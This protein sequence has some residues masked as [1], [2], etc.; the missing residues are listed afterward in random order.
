MG[1]IGKDVE[2]EVF[3]EPAP[4]PKVPMPEPIREPV[5]AGLAFTTASGEP[6][7]DVRLSLS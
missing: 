4:P 2:K 5:P 1:Q 7:A 3:P 6:F